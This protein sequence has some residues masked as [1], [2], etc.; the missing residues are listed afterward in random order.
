[1]IT[2]QELCHI[3]KLAKLHLP[4]ERIAALTEDM[5]QII[6]F[7]EQVCAASQQCDFDG[8]HTLQNAWREDVIQ[9]SFAQA[10]VLRGAGGGKN[11]Y[12]CALPEKEDAPCT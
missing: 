6:G 4:P 7:A 11:G 8:V 12:F 1:M 2:Q 5:T 9:P 3:A 10:D